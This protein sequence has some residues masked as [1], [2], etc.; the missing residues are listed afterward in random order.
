MG[1]VDSPNG[2]DSGRK[3][4]RRR[5]RPGFHIDMTPMVDVAFL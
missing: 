2:R 4:K 5:K 3:A 1:M